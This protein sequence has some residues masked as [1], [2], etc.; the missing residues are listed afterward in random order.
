VNYI[1]LRDEKENF[2]KILK[3]VKDLLMKG[4]HRP[5]RQ[6]ASNTPWLGEG[7]RGNLPIA[8]KISLTFIAVFADVSMNS[9][10][11]SSA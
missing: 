5:H 11:L 9:K 3:M 1:Y 7:N 2:I 10:L 8:M 6:Q 4:P